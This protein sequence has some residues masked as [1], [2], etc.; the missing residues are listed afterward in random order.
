MEIIFENNN[1]PVWMTVSTVV[2]L[3]VVGIL[4]L[5]AIV[6][7]LVLKPEESAAE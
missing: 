1:L 6:V 3:G 5:A 2:T 7:G 4:S